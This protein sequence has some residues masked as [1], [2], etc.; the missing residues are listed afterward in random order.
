M[1]PDGLVKCGEDA[2]RESVGPGAAW[3]GPERPDVDGRDHEVFPVDLDPGR[4]VD[5]E[6]GRVVGVDVPVFQAPSLPLEPGLPLELGLPLD[7]PEW[8]LYLELE[9]MS[10]ECGVPAWP[11][12]SSIPQSSSRP[13]IREG[14]SLSLL[15]ASLLDE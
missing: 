1:R 6:G 7:N 12:A 4:P 13:S 2:G 9:A 5:C 15:S 11:G 10:E 3:V 14:S 8:I